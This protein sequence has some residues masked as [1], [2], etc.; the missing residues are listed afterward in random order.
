MP[1][2]STH[3]LVAD[4]IVA[5]LQK[6]S[7]DWPFKFEGYKENINSP[8]DLAKLASTYNNYYALGAVGPDLFYFLADFRAKYGLPMAELIKIVDFLENIYGK[9]DEWILSKW[10]HYFGAVNQNIEEEIS[11]LTG[12]LSSV[13]ADIMGRLSSI[14]NAGY[15]RRCR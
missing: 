15:Y 7:T 3:I 10:E 4:E 6:L 1:G 5:N 13:V 8:P 12:D 14:L 11:R 2:P 9:L